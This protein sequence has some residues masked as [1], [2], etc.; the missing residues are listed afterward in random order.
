MWQIIN[1]TDWST[2]KDKF[3]WVQ[4]MEGVPQDSIF[5]AEG[6]VETHTHMV[7]EAVLALP[8][9]QDLE[10]QDQHILV[11]A[12]LLHDV[13]KR[14]TTITDEEGRIRSP[15]H[16]MKGEYSARNILYQEIPTPFF[17]KEMI[18][19]LVRYHGLPLWILEKRNPLEYLLQASLE[20]NTKLLYLLAKADILGRICPDQAE[21][22]E[23]VELFKEYCLEQ[24]CF[25][26]AYPFANGLA[27]FQFFYKKNTSPD[28]IPFDDTTSEVILMCGLPGS[29]KD[30]YIKTYLA[31]Y[32]VISLDEIRKEIGVGHRRQ[33]DTSKVVFIA[34]EQAKT[35][36]RQQQSFVWNATNLTKQLRSSLINLFV[37]YKAKVTIV[38]LEVPH[39]TLLQ[40][41]RNREEIVPL[42]IL[43][44]M[45]KR[46]EVPS[47]CE[48]H[49]VI[50]KID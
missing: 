39:Q 1:T 36:L 7:M 49:Q 13:E 23:R 5:H 15:R 9:Y 43:D 14:S 26:Q 17:I 8:E 24:N 2:I 12:A 10:R 48:A 19:K 37:T 22:L 20:V 6:D 42:K 46:L 3:T 38:Y 32:P 34:K 18:A 40:Q 27:R 44:R 11:A 47:R 35:Y 31:A 4:D 16:A 41:N 50:Y 30:T 21:L 29:G 45:V 28:Y 25:G 33:K